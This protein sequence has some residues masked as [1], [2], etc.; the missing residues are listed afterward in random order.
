[1]KFRLTIFGTNRK[2]WFLGNMGVLIPKMKFSGVYSCTLMQYLR[3][4]K[5]LKVL[6]KGTKFD[7]IRIYQHWYQT[8]GL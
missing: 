8:V 4:F 6:K 2:Q 5:G 1:M 3:P 7:V